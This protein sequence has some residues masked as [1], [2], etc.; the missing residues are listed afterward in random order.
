[1]SFGERVKGGE[2]RTVVLD[3]L[4]QVSLGVIVEMRQRR[5]R[6]RE[7]QLREFKV[8]DRKNGVVGHRECWMSEWTEE[9]FVGGSQGLTRL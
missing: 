5:L 2:E 3:P 7:I 9:N 8:R 1:M 4:E 6:Q